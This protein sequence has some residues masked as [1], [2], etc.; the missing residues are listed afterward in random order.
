MTPEIA[1]VLGLLVAAMVLFAV[2]WLSIDLVALL[3]V[4]ALVVTGIL[5]PREAFSGFANDIIVVLASIFVLS[6][7]LVRTGGLDW[8]GE[9]LR[10]VSGRFEAAMVGSVMSLSAGLSAFLSNTN[11]TAVLIPGVVEFARKTRTAPSRLLIPLAYASMLG[12]T[13]TLIG[14][15]TNLAASGVFQQIGMEPIGLFEL[16][17]VGLVV[18]AVGLAYMVSVGFRFL[19]RTGEASLSEEYRISDYLAEVAV[20]EDAPFAGASL[21]EAPLGER[22]IQVL[23][24][25]RGESRLLPSVSTRILP[26]DLLLIEASRE[27]LL[28]LEETSGLTFPATERELTRELGSGAA[29]L[30]EA[31][32]MPRSRLEGETLRGLDFRRRFGISVLALHRKGRGRPLKI[33]DLPLRV[34]DVLLLL[35][36]PERLAR[37]QRNRDVWVLGEVPH[38]PKRRRKGWIALAALVGGVVLGSTGLVPLPIALLLAAL[39]VVLSGAI[40]VEEMYGLVDWRL[41]VL[42]GSMT[43]FGLAMEET[44]AARYL[45]QAIAAWTLPFGVYTVLGTF[46]VLTMLLTQPLSNA[47]AALV[48]L[49]VAVSTAF[50]IGVEPRSFALLV[51]LAASLSFIAPLEPACLLVYGP[52]KYRFRDFV[53]AGSPLSLLVLLILLLLGP[54]VWPL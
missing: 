19:P 48:V 37:L 54:R 12:G 27:S 43:S 44:G 49:P 5:T 40:G 31:M 41:L 15:S 1:L 36:P 11:V 2:E 16:A 13:C 51:T 32:V 7:T 20:E 29:K 30:A 38:L 52:G 10:R 22:G 21:E 25:H 50:E 6:A 47:A 26:G 24:I 45:A 42:I 53:I 18:A 8:L 23:E 34:G 33:G 9:A 14:T 39:T 46:L 28:E 4:S 3:L 17:P 35:A